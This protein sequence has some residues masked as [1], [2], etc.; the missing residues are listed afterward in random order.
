MTMRG[1]MLTLCLM[2]LAGPLALLVGASEA[3]AKVSRVAIA[4][5]VSG[6]VSVLKSG[7]AKAFKA[8]KNMTLNEGDVIRTGKD[9]S[10]VLE[11]ASDVADQDS[12]TIGANSEVSFTKLKDEK[13]TKAK[14][15][16]WA[17]S[18]WVKVKSVS[19]AD[20]RFEVET[21][22]SIMGVRG[23]HF[24]V[25]V[26]PATGVTQVYLAAGV[27]ESTTAKKMWNV[28]KTE[29]LDGQIFIYPTQQITQLA[30]SDGVQSI[31]SIVDIES[32]V[33]ESSP[34]VIAA[35]IA[36]AASIYEEQ[37][38]MIEKWK[39]EL[40]QPD[41]LEGYSITDPGELERFK[42]NMESFVSM[43]AQQALQQKK[44]EQAD[45]Q[46]LVEQANK[47]AGRVIVDL[48]APA[49]MIQSE[50][51]KLAQ[52]LKQK[53]IEKAKEEQ[54]RKQQ[55]LIEKQKSIADDLL[56][57][58]QDKKQQLSELNQASYNKDYDPD[59]SDTSENSGSSSNGGSV[60]PTVSLAFANSY[61]DN[62]VALG[63]TIPLNVNFT[64]FTSK[65]VYGYQLELQYNA[66]VAAFDSAL[67]AT[68][69]YTSI[70]KLSPFKIEPEGEIVNDALGVDQ[71]KTINSG[72]AT[73]TLVYSAVLV[74]SGTAVNV[75]NNSIVLR[76]PFQATEAGTAVFS[77]K[78]LKVFDKDGNTI[79]TIAGNSLSL[80]IYL[81]RV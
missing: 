40:G 14:L 50:K 53:L 47:E 79:T 56:K 45:L 46:K 10:I 78:S 68:E 57:K 1:V 15:T 33:A 43:I 55:E 7:G 18:L 42:H 35:L 36:N 28:G 51:D 52:E 34:E 60:Q 49:E 11:L 41:G 66:N 69:A 9:G 13:G 16:V 17:G 37:Q 74:Q 24:L 27:I 38:Q 67:Y 29:Q 65:P 20:D 59:K 75:A 64:D 48:T 23:T 3:S 12:V 81:P 72:S 5:K 58:L 8:F 22:T 77:I 61:T 54:N 30:E 19:N 63:Q 26:N 31:T 4:T 39:K 6:T 21:P 76:V 44:I 80:E 71:I 25:N 73:G 32:L 2:L 62:R 70:R